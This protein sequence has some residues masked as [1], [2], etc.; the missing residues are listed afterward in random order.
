MKTQKMVGIA[1][2]AAIAYILSF[3]SFPVLPF[4][5]FL[6]IDFSD[7]PVLVGTFYFGP[8]SGILIAF[9]RSTLH[10]LL[11]GGEMGIPIGDTAAFLASVSYIL[12]IYFWS[13][14]MEWTT[15]NKVVSGILGTMSLT[16]FLTLLNW[17]VLI[18]AYSYVMNFDVG[19]IKDYLL[20]G[21][22]PFNLLKGGLLSVTFFVLYAKLRLPFRVGSKS[23]QS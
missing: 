10:Y 21:I 19:P 5:S 17:F 9:I 13:S 23:M 11:T 8:L 1:L 14:R 3:F 6:K 12:P 20:Y 2:L 4:M 22:V 16:I 18:P 15:K 7:I